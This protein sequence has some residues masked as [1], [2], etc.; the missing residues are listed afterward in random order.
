MTFKLEDLYR[1]IANIAYVAADVAL[2]A[3][4]HHRLHQTFDICE[5]ANIERV[6]NLLALAAEE[7]QQLMHNAQCIMHNLN[8]MHNLNL[9]HNAQCIMINF[10][11]VLTTRDSDLTTQDSDTTLTADNGKRTTENRQQTTDNGKR[12]TENRQQ[13]TD[14]GQLTTENCKYRELIREFLVCR[15]LHGWLS[16][17]L[18]EAAAMW[19]E[20]AEALL[21]RL[22]SISIGS[23][24][25]LTRRLSPF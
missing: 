8:S 14:N 25:P 21:A 10:D 6:N 20:R 22:K 11:S 5:E 12:T 16:V 23:I 9:M 18:P 15:V 24:G 4:N 3:D 1:E 19:H 17:T 13:T 7:V 2:T